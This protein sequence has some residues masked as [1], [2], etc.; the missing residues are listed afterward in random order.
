[1]ERLDLWR[2]IFPAQVQ[3]HRDVDLEV[4]ADKAALSGGCIRNAALSATLLAAEEGTAVTMMHLVKSVGR[5]YENLG[6]LFSEA[7]FFG[8]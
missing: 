4:L 1:M 3:L 5:E 8:I 2:Q 6:K 7:D